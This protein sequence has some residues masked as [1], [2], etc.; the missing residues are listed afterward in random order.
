[1]TKFY[2]DICETEVQ[3]IDL[4][5]GNIGFGRGTIDMCESCFKKLSTAKASLFDEYNSKYNNLDEEYVQAL[6]DEILE[7]NTNPEPEF[8][9]GE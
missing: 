3:R 7:E 6:K 2:C 8:E 4:H 9:G 5:I 1:M